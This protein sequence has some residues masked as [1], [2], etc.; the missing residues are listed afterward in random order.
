MA[1]KF[2]C[3]D[4]GSDSYVKHLS[5]SAEIGTAFFNTDKHQYLP[6]YSNDEELRFLPQYDFD[7]CRSCLERRAM[8]YCAFIGG[9]R[10]NDD[11]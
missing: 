6:A 2:Y 3:D 1:V 9:L 8:E 5:I 10:P 11:C 7:L 4:C